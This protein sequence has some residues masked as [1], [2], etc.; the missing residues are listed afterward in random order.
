V[1]VERSGFRLPSYTADEMEAIERAR[2]GWGKAIRARIPKC[3][4]SPLECGGVCSLF[5]GH[6]PPCSCSGDVPDTCPA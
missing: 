4:A 6:E 3:G 1:T 2:V 5:A